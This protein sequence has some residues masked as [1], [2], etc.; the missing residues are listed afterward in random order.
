MSVNLW[1]YIRNSF[2]ALV[3]MFKNY[4]YSAK[5]VCSWWVMFFCFFAWLFFQ[6]FFISVWMF[7][8]KW[9]VIASRWDC[10]AAKKITVKNRAKE[11]KSGKITFETDP[12]LEVPNMI[13]KFNGFLTGTCKFWLK[14]KE[15][16]EESPKYVK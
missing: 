5:K 3:K 9:R 7:E 11:V 14:M 16:Q 10:V 12:H 13:V 6:S 15:R 4:L 8:T 1:F 2:K